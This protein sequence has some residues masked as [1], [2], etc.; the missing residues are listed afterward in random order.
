[1]SVSSVAVV[2]CGPQG[3]SVIEAFAVSGYPVVAVQVTP[4]SGEHAK[5]RLARTLGFRVELGELNPDGVERALRR[6][7]I[8][9]RLQKVA[10]ADLVIESTVGD[11]RARRAFMATLEGSISRGAILAANANPEQLT[12]MAEVLLR[13]D[14]F[15]GLRFFHPATHTPLVEVS[16][17]PDTA[18]GVIATC[19]QVCRWLEKTPVDRVDGPVPPVVP[20]L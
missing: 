2:G 10:G 16:P 8:T 1:M 15:I 5:R 3:L 7:D 17:L 14:Q 19:E 12:A 9:P 4:G 6:V 20:R 18:P 11:V 13:R